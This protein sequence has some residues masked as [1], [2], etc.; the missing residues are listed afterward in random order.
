MKA[1]RLK[2]IY[3]ACTVAWKIFVWNYFVVGERIIFMAYQYPRKYFN[4]DG[5]R[6]ASTIALL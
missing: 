1:L 6:K 2:F 3:C 5:N 4:N